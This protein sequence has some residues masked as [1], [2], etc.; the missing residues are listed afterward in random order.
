MQ[1]T[2]NNRNY[3]ID[4]LRFLSASWV[5]L[6]HFNAGIPPADNWY[7]AFCG[8]GYLGVPVFFIISGYCIC[9]AQQHAKTPRSFIIRRFFRI[10]PPYWFSILLVCACALAIK[11]ITGTNS[12]ASLPNSFGRVMAA[13]LLYTAPL[14]SEHT[15]NWVY[16]TLP[17]ELFFYFLVF[18]AMAISKQ[19]SAFLLLVLALAAIWVPYQATGFLFF[20]N[21]LPAFLLG[22]ALYLVLH[23]EGNIYAALGLLLSAAAG[24]YLKHVEFAYH[25]TYFATIALIAVNARFPLKNNFFSRLGDYSYSVYLIHVPL[26]IYLL[27]FVK[28]YQAVQNTTVLNILADF[29][30]LTVVVV[31]A[32]VMFMRVEAPSIKLGRKYSA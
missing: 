24:V 17:Y 7:R 32:K 8:L 9:I 29:T 2:T 26:G 28:R 12:A 18:L 14:S 21:E 6:F 11:L 15:I 5:A 31:C 1:A 3:L 23:K 10:F 16:W 22:Y 25:I 20:F 30:L 19:V 13:V 4:L 27:G